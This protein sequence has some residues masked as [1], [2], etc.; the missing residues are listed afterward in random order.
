MVRDASAQVV[1]NISRDLDEIAGI[2]LEW[3]SVIT[4]LTEA[5]GTLSQN[6]LLQ[7]SRFSQ[8][9][10][11]RLAKRMEEEGLVERRPSEHDRRNLDVV[12]T[13]HGQDV[14]LRV[15]A[16]HHSSVQKHFGSRLSDEEAAAL[17]ALMRKVL[18]GPE[19][20]EE[21]NENLEQLLPF[22]ETVLAVTSESTSLRDIAA[23]REA[24]ELPLLLDAARH[25][26]P[27]VLNDLQAHVL[28]MSRLIDEPEE[29]FRADWELH[30]QIAVCC[31]NDVLRT[32][33][34]SLLDAIA[35]HLKR[36]VPTHNLRQY[37]Y[38][39]LAIHARIVDAVASGEPELVKAAVE[40]H[41]YTSSQLYAAMV[42]S[43]DRLPLDS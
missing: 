41:D 26:T 14:F 18:D 36:V 9:G 12:L 40:A 23:T 34:L 19:V 42:Y 39:R 35:S 22:G 27:P 5:G 30:R 29:F 6:E 38:E 10:V 20:E 11:S 15:L 37:L 4:R 7:R 16:V 13:E 25:M 8:S 31:Q 33:Y 2:P 17:T 43:D 32:L 3:Y 24:L 1:R 21:V 28:S